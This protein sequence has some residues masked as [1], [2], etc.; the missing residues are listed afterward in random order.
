MNNLELIVNIFKD[1]ATTNNWSFGHGFVYDLNQKG[2]ETIKETLL[3]LYEMDWLP[4]KDNRTGNNEFKTVSG[5]YFI[6]MKSSMALNYFEQENGV[7]G[8][9]YKHDKYFVPLF[10][11]NK[12]M[13]SSINCDN[14]I[15]I[16][17]MVQYVNY[18]DHNLDGYMVKFTLELDV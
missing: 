4:T 11:A 13:V 15:T 8:S 9:E 3:F 5:T 12:S 1:Y 18:L 14:D 16:Q 17:S 2:N 10:N 6:G 7:K